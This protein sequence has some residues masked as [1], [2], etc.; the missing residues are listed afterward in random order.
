MLALEA[1]SGTATV[2]TQPRPSPLTRWVCG[3]M[4]SERGGKGS[5]GDWRLGSA[6]PTSWTH[7]NALE[8]RRLAHADH[9]DVLRT[10][11]PHHRDL[12]VTHPT[13]AAEVVISVD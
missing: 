7:L 4:D 8:R 5:L 10:I 1:N 11:E 2:S 9:R 12:G 13:G 6:D 3:S